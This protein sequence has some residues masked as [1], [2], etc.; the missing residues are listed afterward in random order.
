MNLLSSWSSNSHL[1][2]SYSQTILGIDIV[3]GKLG[4]SKSFGSFFKHYF[5][6]N[7]GKEELEI[8]FHNLEQDILFKYNIDVYITLT[9]NKTDT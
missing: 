2:K 3:G 6:F 8:C 9:F 1:H 7:Q 5:S 4:S